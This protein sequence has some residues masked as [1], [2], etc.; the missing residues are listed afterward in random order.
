MIAVRWVHLQDLLL[1][2]RTQH[3]DD[4]DELVDA[5]LVEDE[6]VSANVDRSVSAHRGSPE[7]PGKKTLPCRSSPMMQPMDQRSARPRR[8]VSSA[9]FSALSPGRVPMVSAEDR[10]RSAG[11]FSANDN[12]DALLYFVAPKMSSGAR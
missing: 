5:L 9:G 2:R 3:L 1:A 11:V 12:R 7:E 6:L 4:L 10:K 8:E